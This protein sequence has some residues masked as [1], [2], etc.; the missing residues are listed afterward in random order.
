MDENTKRRWDVRFAFVTVFLSLLTLAVGA[1]QFIEN[2]RSNILLSS[3]L[4]SEAA[5]LD[6]RREVYLIRLDAL[7]KTSNAV[8]RV[9]TDLDLGRDIDESFGAFLELYWGTL[10][11]VEGGELER[12]MVAFRR[13]VL[14]F[15]DGW[16]DEADLKARALE[17][18]EGIRL[19]LQSEQNVSP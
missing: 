14:S 1:W 19:D 12:N 16:A 6:F 3:R 13:E 17:L 5:E 10:V 18:L 7:S 8:G 15:K 11:L 2:Q 9:V 4:Q